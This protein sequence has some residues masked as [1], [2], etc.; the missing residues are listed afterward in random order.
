MEMVI[1]YRLALTTRIVAK[2]SFRGLMD[3]LTPSFSNLLI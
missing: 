3:A 2:V 1:F